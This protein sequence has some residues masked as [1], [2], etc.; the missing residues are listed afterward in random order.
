MA[1]KGCRG[2]QDP[3]LWSSTHGEWTQE[4]HRKPRVQEGS[5]RQQ[6][7]GPGLRF[8]NAEAARHSKVQASTQPSVEHME[9]VPERAKELMAARVAEVVAIGE[10]CVISPR[11]W[12]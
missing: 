8:L 4:G 7:G 10:I 9:C 6:A 1:S 11:A 3:G 2:C 12:Y 5:T